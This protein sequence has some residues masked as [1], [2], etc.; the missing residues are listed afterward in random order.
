MVT[1]RGISV[2]AASGLAW[3]AGRTLGIGELYAVSVAGLAVVL[4]GL[5]YVR[6]ASGA[7][8]ARRTAD[9][10]RVIAGSTVDATVELRND[11]RVPSPTLRLVEQLPEG[12]GAVGHPV[13]GEAR[14][15]VEG[16][17]PGAVAPA[18]YRIA[19]D[20]RGRFRIGPAAVRLGDPFGVAERVRRFS[21]TEDLLVY[22]RIEPLAPVTVRGSHM[23]AGASDTRRVFAAGDDFY[24]M[25]EYVRGDD[26][27]HVHWPST[28]HRQTLMVRQMEQ[29]WQ[30]HATVY[31]DT[32]TASHSAG[33]AGSLEKSVSLA[34]SLVF[35]LAEA[36]YQIRL[37]TDVTVG[38]IGPQPWE[39]AMDQLAV[40]EPS[41]S[42]NLGPS[43]A[44]TRGGEGLFAAV[45]GVPPGQEDLLRHRDMQ[46]LFGVKGFGQRLALIV[47]ER[48]G[49]P[50]AERAAVLLRGAGW[51]AATLAPGVP[52]ADVWAVLNRPLSRHGAHSR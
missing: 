41:T 21:S 26:L 48:P 49:D 29:P 50:R 8:S 33:P 27:R 11:S 23:G 32:R 17:A 47:A 30:A 5:L 2:L 1:S 38:R 28:A 25:R 3:L 16:L 19:A 36:E 20:V 7:V 18:R 31:L 40:L 46:G 43:L 6:S 13:G 42:T 9:A 34:A 44:A 51:R 14:F 39:A 37:V 4:L 15:V 12:L 24:T 45:L 22:P 35:H 10:A 52:L